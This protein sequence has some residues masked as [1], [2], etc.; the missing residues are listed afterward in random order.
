MNLAFSE[1]RKKE[2]RQEWDIFRG[3]RVD[4]ETRESKRRNRVAGT[5]DATL[6]LRLLSRVPLKISHSCLFPFSLSSSNASFTYLDSALIAEILST[7]PHVAFN[8]LQI[9]SHPVIMTFSLPFET[10]LWHL[11]WAQP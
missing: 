1:E 5:A 11:L 3:T 10:Q 8:A 6:F 9:E 7:P 2:K 4:S